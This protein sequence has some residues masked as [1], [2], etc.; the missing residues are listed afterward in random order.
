MSANLSFRD[1]SRLVDVKVHFLRD[2]VRR[3]HVKLVK[4]VTKCTSECVGR[5]HQDFAV[6]TTLEEDKGYIIFMKTCHHRRS[7]L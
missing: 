2:L 1:W 5:I 3:V 4:C 6:R 7:E